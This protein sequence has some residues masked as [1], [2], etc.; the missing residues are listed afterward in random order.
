V[1][2]DEMND[3]N[4]KDSFRKH[5]Q[6]MKNKT[7]IEIPTHRLNQE[8]DEEPMIAFASSVHKGGR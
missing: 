6:A 4:V 2:W 1:S 8:N 5:Y 7:G 3:P